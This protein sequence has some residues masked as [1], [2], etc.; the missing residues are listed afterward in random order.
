MIVLEESVKDVHSG[1]G[2][3]VPW[4]D[5]VVAGVVA[6]E[7]EAD[8]LLGGDVSDAVSPDGLDDWVGAVCC[9]SLQPVLVPAMMIE[10]ASALRALVFM[11][12]CVS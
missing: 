6:D 5:L 9:P 10:R 11:R 8:G 12:S 4:A 2:A 7:A 1:T 3:R